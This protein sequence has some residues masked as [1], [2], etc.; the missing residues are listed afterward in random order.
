MKQDVKEYY[1]VTEAAR[2]LGYERS[3]VRRHCETGRLKAI[4][5][6]GGYII[7]LKD[8]QEFIKPPRGNPKY[9]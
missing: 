1:T 8:L 6:S 4:K 2:Y 3:T 7:K 9:F 5:H